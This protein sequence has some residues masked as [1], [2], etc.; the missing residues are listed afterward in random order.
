MEWIGDASDSDRRFEGN[1]DVQ[2]E[3]E[4][5]ETDPTISDASFRLLSGEL[6]QYNNTRG[7]MATYP[8]LRFADR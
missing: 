5:T 1:Y 4:K 2:E 3:E 7:K 8:E 6:S